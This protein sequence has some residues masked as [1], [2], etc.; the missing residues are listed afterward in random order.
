MDATRRQRVLRALT[1]MLLGTGF[2]A[3]ATLDPL[4]AFRWP[5]F[6]ALLATMCAWTV[7]ENWALKQDEPKEYAAKLQTRIMQGTVIL[8]VVVGVVDAWHFPLAGPRGAA[9]TLAGVTI[10][11]AGAGIRLVAIR[12]LDRH[13]S[14]ELRVEK[15]H[16]IV[17]RGIYSVLRHPSYLGIILV[18]A[19]APLIVQSLLGAAV[20][21][22]VMSGVTVWRI[23]T[24]ERML[25]Q[26]FG[27][28]YA[29]YSGRSWRLLPY[30]Y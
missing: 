26:A 4:A 29:D 25:R 9:L 17:Q 1:L 5:A 15:D 24:E 22:V 16:E 3:L 8:G 19:G 30:V 23:A 11:S 20:G 10:V 7:V 21:L 27:D 2:T 14:Y 18:A 6:W 13:F 28:E 12:T